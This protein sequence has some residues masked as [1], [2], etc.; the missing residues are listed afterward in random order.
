M[1]IVRL[2]KTPCTGGFA[3]VAG[4]CSSEP[5]IISLPASIIKSRWSIQTSLSSRLR[6][7]IASCL[8]W[9]CFC[10]ASGKENQ[11]KR[12][13]PFYLNDQALAVLTDVPFK[14][15]QTISRT[16]PFPQSEAESLTVCLSDAF[17]F[18]LCV[19][20]QVARAITHAMQ[21]TTLLWSPPAQGT[22][23]RWEV[24]FVNISLVIYGPLK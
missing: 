10:I 18:F 3:W 13:P 2:L 7:N 16:C 5:W 9:S 6:M 15:S 24:T 1:L 14:A 23:R 8:I 20:A 12:F 22:Y 17:E 4:F 19:N 11:V 21:Q